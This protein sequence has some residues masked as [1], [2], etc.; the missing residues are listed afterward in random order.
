[1]SVI[2]PV[3]SRDPVSCSARAPL[4]ALLSATTWEAT[5]TEAPIASARVGNSPPCPRRTYHLQMEKSGAGSD[6]VAPH[7]LR[8][9]RHRRDCDRG[10]GGY[11]LGKFGRAVTKA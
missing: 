11:R 9:I 5:Q 7:R 10:R 8:A 3:V 2:R 6:G 1:M 4:P